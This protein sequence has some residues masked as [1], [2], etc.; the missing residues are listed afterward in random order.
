MRQDDS[1]YRVMV[2]DDGL[3]LPSG[4]QWPVPGKIG[5][6]IVQSLRES[7]EIEIGVASAAGEGM[8]VTLS[9]NPKAIP[10]RA[11]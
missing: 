8:R 6:L 1:N 7:T 9:F 11:N 5:S 10:R 3:G 4:I 2:S